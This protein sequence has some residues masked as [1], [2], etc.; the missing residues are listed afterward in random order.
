M[1]PGK[2]EVTYSRTEKVGLPNWS[3]MGLTAYAKS[4]VPTE[5]YDAGYDFLFNVVE[6]FLS[7]R[8]EAAMRALNLWA[9]ATTIIP[10]VTK[11]MIVPQGI[12]LVGTEVGFTVKETVGLPEKSSIDIFA[13]SKRAAALGDELRSLEEVGLVLSAQLKAKRDVVIAKPRPWIQSH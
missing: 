9:G 12:D 5:Q 1:E 3:F 2:T 8:T 13:S 4:T 10:E 6:T 7:E 11:Q